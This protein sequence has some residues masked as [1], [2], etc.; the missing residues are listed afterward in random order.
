MTVCHKMFFLHGN[1]HIAPAESKSTDDQI[2]TEQPGVL[3]ENIFI[4]NEIPPFLTV[5]VFLIHKENY[6]IL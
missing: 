5:Y 2:D 6:I 1:D 3:F 4:H